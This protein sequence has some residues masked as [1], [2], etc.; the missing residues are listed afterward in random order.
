ML[1]AATRHRPLLRLVP[2]AIAVLLGYGVLLT[3]C[4]GAV[5]GVLLCLVIMLSAGFLPRVTRNTMAALTPAVILLV[6][7][8]AVPGRLHVWLDGLYGRPTGDFSGRLS[9]W[10]YA[11]S[12]WW[13]TPFTGSGAGVFNGTNMFG[14][15]P[16]NVLLTVGNDLGL[17]GVALYFGA[18]AGALVTTARI[19]RPGLV[20][21]CGFAAAML[22][23]WLS[24][25]W[26]TALPFWLVLAVLTT[27]PEVSAPAR[28]CGERARRLRRAGTVSTIEPSTTPGRQ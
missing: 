5:I 6:P 15:G 20:Y 12:S 8:G 10:P 23:I 28:R 16:H 26:E 3:R 27:L 18:M 1:V 17:V 25:Q 21:A 9:I 24:G 7:I 14:F 19:S 22:P 4:R 13:D 2:L 11:L